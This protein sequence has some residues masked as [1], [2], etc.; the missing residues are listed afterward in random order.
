MSNITFG[1]GILTYNKPKTLET[2]LETYKIH[3]LLDMCDE[4]I[5]L[6]QGNN[7]EERNIANKYNLKIYHTDSNIGIGEGNN[8]LIDKLTSEYFIILQNDFNLIEN[9]LTEIKKG[10]DLLKEDK[11]HCYRL[12]HLLNPGQPCYCAYRIPNET[13]G[14]THS[15]GVLFYNFIQNPEIRYPHIFEKYDSIYI[16]SSKYCNYT[17][18]PC[19]YN[20]QWYLNTIYPFNKIEGTE[21]ENNVQNFWQNKDFKIGIGPGLFS[22]NDMRC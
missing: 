9:P 8:F 7:N 22:H 21:A 3:G 19:L 10:I 11:I 1:I 18:N 4:K 12:R 17:E 2:T 6:L 15:S 16:I 13:I 20:R 14:E 5:I